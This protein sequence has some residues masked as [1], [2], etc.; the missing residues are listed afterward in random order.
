[1]EKIESVIN[2]SEL[3]SFMFWGLIIAWAWNG[4][5]AAILGTR[6]RNMQERV[7]IRKLE[8]TEDPQ[9]CDWKYFND[10]G[11]WWTGCGQ[12]L[13]YPLE[14]GTKKK[15]QTA[16]YCHLCGGKIREV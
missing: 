15:K 14:E 4:I 6:Y 2:V 16:E 10:R 13:N 12:I 7:E 9:G 11:D 8:L 5:I 1:M 3:L